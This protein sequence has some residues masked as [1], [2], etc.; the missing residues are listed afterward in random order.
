M[1]PE[2]P[3]KTL[4]GSAQ[5]LALSNTLA[6]PPTAGC[7]QRVDLRHLCTM[8][9]QVYSPSIFE[10][11]E[12]K[13]R[14]ATLGMTSTESSNL[15]RSH[16]VCQHADQVGGVQEQNKAQGVLGRLRQ[17]M[18]SNLTTGEDLKAGQASY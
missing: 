10:V 6:F 3:S 4:T 8:P 9:G 11:A 1:H 12:V 5:S 16:P 2:F 18:T 7:V 15:N 17:G 13:V 14:P